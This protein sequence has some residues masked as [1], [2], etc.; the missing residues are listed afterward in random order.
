VVVFNKGKV[1]QMGP[2][3]QLYEHP[4]TPFVTEFLGSVN[5]LA[6]RSV[7]GTAVLRDGM[8]LPAGD[9]VPDGP[10]S[11]YVRPHDLEITRHH[12]DEPSWPVKVSRL[13]PLVG[14]ERVEVDLGEST[15]LEIELTRE[16]SRELDLRPGD[17]VFVIPKAPK[18]FQE[19]ERSAANFAI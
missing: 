5:V 11:V 17:Q 19:G 3:Q 2:P 8:L 4:A 1:E 10:V 12:G 15:D 16:R 18:V 13:V 6:G 9:P 14:L 7:Q